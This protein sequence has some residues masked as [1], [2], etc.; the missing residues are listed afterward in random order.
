MAQPNS[1]PP[2]ARHEGE[3]ERPPADG[4]RGAPVRPAAPERHLG[5]RPGA[6]AE[7]AVGDE[8]RD[9]A[10]GEPRAGAEG[11]P[12]TMQMTVTG[13]TPGR[14]EKTP[15][16]PPPTA[17]RVATSAELLGAVA[18]ALERH[19][20]ERQRDDQHQDDRERGAHGAAS[21][22][23]CRAAGRRPPPAIS[24]ATSP[25]ERA[26]PA[27]WVAT[28]TAAPSAARARTKARPAPPCE[29]GPCRGWARRGRSPPGRRRGSR[30]GPRAPAA[31]PR[32]RAVAGLQAAEAERLERLGDP[33]APLRPAQAQ[34]PQGEG[35]LVVDALGEQVSPGVLA[36]SPT[37][38]E[39]ALGGSAVTSAPASSTARRPAGAAR[40]APAGGSSC[41]SRSAPG[42]W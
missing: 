19:H 37:R 35:D 29:P 4:P 25:A 28:T 39:A 1:I 34:P 38:E 11:R 42:G 2:D 21:A 30:P 18:A 7:E 13:C 10:D 26:K 3:P 40:R 16:R 22:G 23:A 24:S 31:R 20:A 17:P 27:S 8:A 15:V 41:R 36:H 6:L 33:G 9:R 14:G 32:G 12:E 5:R